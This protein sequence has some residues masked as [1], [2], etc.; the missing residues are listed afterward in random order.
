M[1]GLA[2]AHELSCH[3]VAAEIW[4][5]SR[6]VSGRAGS[7]SRHGAIYDFGANFFKLDDPRVAELVQQVLPTD[8]LA[9]I[10]GD[11]DIL[12]GDGSI[13]PGDPATNAEAKWTY[14][15]GI[16]TLGKLLQAAAPLAQ[17]HV[18]TR[19]ASL[20]GG[21]GGWELTDLDGAV[22]GPYAQVLL[23]PPAPQTADLLRTVGSRAAPVVAAL[24]AVHYHRQFTFV[25]GYEERLPRTAG[26]HALVQ[27]D[28]RHPI[29][30][31]SFED[32]KPGH[33][34]ADRSVLVVQMAP[35]WSDERYACEPEALLPEVLAALRPVL[36]DPLPDPDWWDWQRWGCAQPTSALDPGVVTQLEPTGLF[37][38]G[39][40]L[41]GKGRVVR[42]VR[43]GLDAAGRMLAQRR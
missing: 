33:V 9:R 13:T 14:R 30:W 15:S 28:G 4:E 19:I 37:L 41:A 5:K 23:T 22:H 31:L 38:A 18:T 1:A 12:H 29:A 43:T 8:E 25:L 26:R 32:D 7:R 20:Q 21:E 35:G 2:A 16:K 24:E 3:G 40:A 11:V 17:L 34:A 39:D 10:D 36:P 27:L 6:G 42:A